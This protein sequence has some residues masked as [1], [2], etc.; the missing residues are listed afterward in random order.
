MPIDFSD[1]LKPSQVFTHH[2]SSDPEEVKP[3]NEMGR[4]I[5]DILQAKF[6][7]ILAEINTKVS[8][9]RASRGN[10]AEYGGLSGDTIKAGDLTKDVN[11]RTDK[12]WHAAELEASTPEILEG[13]GIMMH[14]IHHARE[15]ISGIAGYKG[16]KALGANWK[17]AM[18]DAGDM[19]FPSVKHAPSGG[20]QLSE[21]LATATTIKLL[22]RANIV[23]TGIFKD[24]KVHLGE[25]NKKYPWLDGFV[26]KYVSPPI[27][28]A[29]RK[30]E[31]EAE[32]NNKPLVRAIKSIEDFFREQKGN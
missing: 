19:D 14:E 22:E 5:V 13:V 15:R 1:Y 27:V 3:P 4:L 32:H 12:Y 28:A 23:P 2:R 21:F 31:K 9:Q 6:P 24:L 18:I 7:D 8:G 29:Q 26:D 11:Y 25:L 20:D 30:E 10:I 16:D 17:Q